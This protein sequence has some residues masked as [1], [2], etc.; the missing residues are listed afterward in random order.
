LVGIHVV[1]EKGN[2]CHVDCSNRGICNYNSGQCTCF[3]GFWGDACENL[4]N[5][6]GSKTHYTVQHNASVLTRI[7]GN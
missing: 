6:G 1:G 3:D 7:E 5:T 2:I 4:A